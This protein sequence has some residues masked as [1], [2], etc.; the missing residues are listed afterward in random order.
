MYESST[1]HLVE[2]AKEHHEKSV[3]ITSMWVKNRTQVLPDGN[4]DA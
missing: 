1:E 4:D 2:V 3:R